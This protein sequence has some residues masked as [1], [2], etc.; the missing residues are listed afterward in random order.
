[1]SFLIDP[2]LLILSGLA[3]YFIGQRLEWSRQS[4]IVIGSGVVLVFI[5]F[6]SLLYADLIKCVFPFFSGLKGSDFMLHTNFTGISKA[7]VPSF[8]VFF[9]FL[10][11]PFWMFAGYSTALLLQKQHRESKETY[12][13]KDVRSRDRRGSSDFAVA[14]NPKADQAVKEAIANIGGMDKF[15][16]QGDKVLIKANICGGVPEIKG[17]FTS[18]DV[19]G[20]VVDM[21]RAA[22]GDPTIADADM[23]WTKFWKAAEDSGWKEWARRKG[24]RLLN[25]SETKIV[26]FDFGKDSALGVERVSKELI[27]ADVIISMPT[28]KT[29]L[30]TGVTLGMK[31]MYGTFPEVDKAKYH[32]KQ[33]EDVIYEINSAFRPTLTVIDGTIGGEAIGPLSCRPV[34]FQTVV[35]SGDVVAADSVASQLMGYDPLDITHIHKASDNGLGNV[36]VKYD[37]DDLPYEHGAGKDGNWDRPDPRVKDFYEWGIELLLKLPGWETLF[38]IGADFF[39]YDLARLPVLRYF[40]PAFLQLLNDVVYLHLSKKETEESRKRRWFNVSFVAAVALFSLLGFYLAG[41]PFHSN[42]AFDLGYLLAIVLAAVG[43]ARMRT[44]HL[45][46]LAASSALFSL[47]VETTN[48]IAGL[49]SYAGMPQA[50][51]FV[52]GGWIILMIS[53]LYLADLLRMWFLRLGLLSRLQ[54]WRNLPF[55]AALA[56]FLVFMYWE[57]YLIEA[58]PD[59]WVMYAAMAAIGLL[60][61]SHSSAEWNLAIIVVSISLGGFTDLLGSLAGF[62]QYRYGEP[63]A[64]CFVLSWAINSFAVY[65]FP[66]FFGIDVVDEGL[67]LPKRNPFTRRQQSSNCEETDYKLRFN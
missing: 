15:V 58:G 33:I 67:R 7:Q 46:I 16:R 62:W 32:R 59:V 50:Y 14:R 4:K 2:P 25:L 22:G 57:G 26:R 17:T 30:L 36:R 21:V 8:A 63:L 43:A 27:D 48:T 47:V 49:L 39:L 23:V 11:Y 40:T 34:N 24:V 60:M 44:R 31:N 9:L 42:L 52:V 38:N 20:V 5:I 28:M 51:L 41:Y 10:L 6:S 37:L 56:L 1:M 55:L 35:A 61:S 65:G 12:S 66:S 54:P 45:L 19:A 18:I 29:H 53:I 13:L 64:I 3:I